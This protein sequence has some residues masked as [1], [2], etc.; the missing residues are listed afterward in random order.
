[1][2]KPLVL[3]VIMLIFASITLLA[4]W[5]ILF[6]SNHQDKKE[7]NLFENEHRDKKEKNLNIRKPKE[8]KTEIAFL[9]GAL[10]VSAQ[11]LNKVYSG[12]YKYK[13]DEW[14]PEISYTEEEGTGYLRIISKDEEEDKQYDSSDDNEWKINLTKET[15]N[16]LN[17]RM[18]A[19]IGRF[20]LAGSNLKSF[21]FQMAAG[22]ADIN[23]S[24]T[25]V[26]ELRIKAIA[27]KAIID[28]TGEWNNDLH[29]SVTGGIG[30]LS[31]ILPEEIGTKMEITGI[32]AN[33]YAPGFEK[34]GHTY[35][36]SEYGNTKETM[37]IEIFGGIGEI[38]VM[39]K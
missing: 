21:D 4:T 31:F 32:L 26:P 27:G 29:A 16:D 22:E 36:N 1:M 15:R 23:L 28:L 5:D 38:D 24:N 33:I 8:V 25:S 13:K 19:G 17:I 18:G 39:M 20:Q 2:K 14:K 37:Y 11:T 3:S 7:K 30:E 35:T 6:E 10:T 12:D 34:N 9:N